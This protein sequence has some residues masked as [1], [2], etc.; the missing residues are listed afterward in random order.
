[1]ALDDAV[2][3]LSPSTYS[4]FI[5]IEFWFQLFADI[6]VGGTWSALC[7]TPAPAKRD[8]PDTAVT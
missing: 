8:T 5:E 2:S 1:M 4:F 3:L 7:P 6:S